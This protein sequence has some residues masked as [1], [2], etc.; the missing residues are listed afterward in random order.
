VNVLSGSAV[1]GRALAHSELVLVGQVESC[2]SSRDDD[3][4][5]GIKA[6]RR[7]GE[8]MPGAR[9]ASIAEYKGLS[10]DGLGL[11][12]TPVHRVVRGRC[13]TPVQPT[14]RSNH[15]AL[16]LQRARLS[17]SDSCRAVPATE[18][19]QQCDMGAHD[20]CHTTTAARY[21]P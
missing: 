19:T 21:F 18:L 15:R 13:L 12:F 9:R 20:D 16:Q 11:A 8:L 6:F 5:I 10:R 1:F 7:R 4:R 3:G 14:P 2:S 17:L